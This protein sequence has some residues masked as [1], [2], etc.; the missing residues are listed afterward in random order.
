MEVMKW[1]NNDDFFKGLLLR[2]FGAALIAL[3][4]GLVL[5]NLFMRITKEG[6]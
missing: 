4:L 1:L 2:V 5:I 3:F 6:D